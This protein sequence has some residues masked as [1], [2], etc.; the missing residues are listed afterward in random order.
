[1]L[2]GKTEHP[3][4]KLNMRAEGRA[5]RELVRWNGV[6]QEGIHGLIGNKVWT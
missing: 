2:E 4:L 3:P 5:S 6:E 1:M